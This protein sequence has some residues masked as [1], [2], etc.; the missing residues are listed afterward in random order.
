M[1]RKRGKKDKPSE[2]EV[3]S[4]PGHRLKIKTPAFT[5]PHEKRKDW[6]EKK[7]R[8]RELLH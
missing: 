6:M 7:R 2:G 5:I 4:Q 3:S 1:R 8:N